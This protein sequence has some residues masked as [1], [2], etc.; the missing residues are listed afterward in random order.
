MRLL[1]PWKRLVEEIEV[2]RQDNRCWEKGLYRQ[3]LTVPGIL[4]KAS[5]GR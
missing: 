2:D 4:R 3:L 1:L 5:W